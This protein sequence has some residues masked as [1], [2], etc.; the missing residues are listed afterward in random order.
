MASARQGNALRSAQSP[1]EWANGLGPPARRIPQAPTAGAPRPLS[2][3]GEPAPSSHPD[4]GRARGATAT[5]PERPLETRGPRPRAVGSRGWGP[6][7]GHAHGLRGRCGVHRARS[8][9]ALPGRFGSG[10]APGAA[11][12]SG[13][14]GRTRAG[15]QPGASCPSA[16]GSAQLRAGRRSHLPGPPIVGLPAAGPGRGGAGD[17]RAGPGRA[18]QGGLLWEARPAPRA[19]PIGRPGAAG[20]AAWGSC[21]APSSGG[22]SCWRPSARG[23]SWPCS[24]R[25][26]SRARGPRPEPGRGCRAA[27]NAEGAGDRP[28]GR[29]A[30]G[31]RA[32]SWG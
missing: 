27:P 5:T 29:A 7:L 30:Q 16:S 22:C 12:G 28:P 2:R 9:H 10:K 13:R 17:A 1:S 24:P 26:G 32:A 19:R 25:R 3:P 4:S 18:G 8:P 11:P 23:S 6:G 31:P 15:A 21:A 20:G 14:P